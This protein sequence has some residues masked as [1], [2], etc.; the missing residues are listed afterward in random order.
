MVYLMLPQ[1]QP[2]VSGFSG[3]MDVAAR[4]AAS[5]A[6]SSVSDLIVL[7]LFEGAFWFCTTFLPLR[8]S[9]G[10]RQIRHQPAAA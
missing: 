3:E 9:L 10:S 1:K 4:G 8:C 5:D 2:P 6:I 7:S